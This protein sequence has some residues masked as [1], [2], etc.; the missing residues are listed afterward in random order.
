MTIEVAIED[1]KESTERHVL[2]KSTGEWTTYPIPH[3]SSPWPAH[4]GYIPRT[5]NAA[6]GDELD[7]LLLADVDLS[8]GV[9]LTATAVGIL[10]RPDEDHKV[11]DVAS[12]DPLSGIISRFEDGPR[13][14]I[15]AIEHWFN[16][17][18][19]LGQF[20]D[21]HRA[22]DEIEQS[23]ERAKNWAPE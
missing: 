3:S 17:W 2:D 20:E 12:D 8:T 13:A 9:S 23:L 4:Y 18:S 7:V 22:I 11:L 14:C 16:E 6:D 21:E 1:P 15:L 5:L 19:E 10:L